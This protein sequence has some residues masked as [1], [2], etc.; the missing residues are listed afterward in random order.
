MNKKEIIQKLIDKDD[1]RAY[2]YAKQIGIES[3]K[4]NK[5]V[6]MIPDFT[7]MLQDNNSFV[8][9]RFFVLI[10]NQ[11]R[12][13]NNKQ[14]EDVYDQMKTLLND[15]KPTVVRQCLNALHEVVLF[16]PEMCDAI[17][18]TLSKIDFSIYKDSMA[19]LIKKDIDELMKL[20]SN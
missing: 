2:E 9:T 20:A 15:P 13:A 6:E 11:A 17:I 7:S 14:I 1:K 4:T 19:P 16:R 12:W 18:K 8:R 3:A 10:C 5:Y